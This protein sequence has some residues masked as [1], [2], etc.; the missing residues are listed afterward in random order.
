MQFN[1]H[2]LL[3]LSVDEVN[4]AQ[5][6]ELADEL[7][8][9]LEPVEP[10]DR[11]HFSAGV[12]VLDW[13]SISSELG[14][15]VL[16]SADVRVVGVHGYNVPEP[17]ESFLPE[18]GVATGRRLSREVF[19]ALRDERRPADPVEVEACLAGVGEPEAA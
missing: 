16:R 17:L 3:Y 4:I 14:T 18:R 8:L 13:D 5:A 19:E 7:G 11:A 15:S 10:R 12:L 6:L 9:D 2:R 1:R